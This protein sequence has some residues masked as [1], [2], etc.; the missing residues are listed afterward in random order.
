MELASS[1]PSHEVVGDSWSPDGRQIAFAAHDGVHLLDVRNHREQ[2][3]TNTSSAISFAWRPD[4]RHLLY[5][6]GELVREINLERGNSRTVVELSTLHD[7]AKP[8]PR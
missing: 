1:C 6:D 7:K 5:S 4:S 3:L 8:P 2:L